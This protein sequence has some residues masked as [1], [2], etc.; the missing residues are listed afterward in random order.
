MAKSLTVKHDERP[1]TSGLLTGFLLLSIVWMALST[2]GANLGAG[3]AQ[4]DAA[5]I[6]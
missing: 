3:P 2:L 5:I 6:E 1:A 4:A